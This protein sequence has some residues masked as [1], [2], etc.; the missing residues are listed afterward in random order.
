MSDYGVPATALTLDSFGKEVINILHGYLCNKKLT[1]SDYLIGILDSNGIGIVDFNGHTPS[2]VKKLGNQSVAS[3]GYSSVESVVPTYNEVI[4]HGFPQFFI[5]QEWARIHRTEQMDVWLSQLGYNLPYFASLRI[6]GGDYSDKRPKILKVTSLII[7]ALWNNGVNFED[8][9]GQK[10]RG[11]LSEIV[12]PLGESVSKFLYKVILN[13]IR[14]KRGT[15]KRD[16]FPKVKAQKKSNPRKAKKTETNS[17]GGGSSD[18]DGLQDRDEEEDEEEEEESQDEEEE[19]L[20]RKKP[21]APNSDE[22]SVDEELEAVFEKNKKAAKERQAK[23]DNFVVARVNGG[24]RVRM[25]VKR[26]SALERAVKKREREQMNDYVPIGTQSPP[27]SFLI[28]QDPHNR[29][30]NLP[31]SAIELEKKPKKPEKPNLLKIL[32]IPRI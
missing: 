11:E 27:P 2:S 12:P 22:E 6:P 21:N 32:Q 17:K 20:I 31:K 24:P 7:S 13:R 30:L 14:S 29:K 23:R 9:G 18:E 4:S 28:E 5:D 25:T 8:L 3:C 19:R 26:A 1:L 10:G 16:M 15:I